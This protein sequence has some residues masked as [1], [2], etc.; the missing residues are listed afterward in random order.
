MTA[1][2]ILVVDDHEVV[3]TGLRTVLESADGLEVVAE[4]ATAIAAIEEAIAHTP[5]VV[6]MDVRLADDGGSAGIDACRQIKSQLPDT[7]VLM[8][9]SFTEREAVIASVLAG[10]SGYITKNLERSQLIEAIRSV[11][12]GEG[13]LDSRVAGTVIG[14]LTELAGDD[15]QPESPLTPRER[16]V[17]VLISRGLTN[18]EIASDLV[19]SEHTARNHVTSILNKL[20]FSRRAEAAAYAARLGIL[21]E[22][23]PEA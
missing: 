19:I 17:L 2:R 5:D 13:Q 15:A 20:G 6:L 10:A 22:E 8:F 14:R 21:D 3:R 11:A 12:R 4:A 9:S 7:H 18:R 23:R 1:T 16:E